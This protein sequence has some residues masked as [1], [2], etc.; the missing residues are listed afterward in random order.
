MGEDHGTC[1]ET[2]M[3]HGRILRYMGKHE[4]GIC[5]SAEITCEGSIW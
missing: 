3:Q 2:G 4:T 5:Y 1:K